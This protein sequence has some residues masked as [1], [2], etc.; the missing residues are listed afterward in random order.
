MDPNEFESEQDITL[1]P[2]EGHRLEHDN[3]SA[4]ANRVISTGSR[5]IWAL[6]DGFILMEEIKPI[7]WLGTPSESDLG[8]KA[9]EQRHG[10]ARL[11]LGCFYVSGERNVLIDLGYGPRDEMNRGFM[12]GG[13][14]LSHLEGM[15]VTPD[16]IDII[17]LT[18]L[19][20]DHVGWLGS[21]EG[22]PTF[23][24]AQVFI[25]VADWQYFVEG[26]NANLPLEPHVREALRRLNRRGQI[27]FMEGAREIAPGVQRVPAPG[28]TPG[29]S[30]YVVEDSA[31]R[32]VLCGDA[33]YC[34]DH[35][36]HPEWQAE[37]DIDPSL[38]RQTRRMLIDDLRE[39]GGI[40]VGS[41]FPGLLAI[42]SK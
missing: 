12:I 25:G 3:L 40:A 33:M 22:E 16:D 5:D 39:H 11:P 21:E 14:L 29:H 1:P 42:P 17:G 30:V 8:Q 35:V 19:H 4:G 32:V 24:N 38:A 26:D 23:G 36:E 7:F 34:P 27:T 9:L 31:T 10:E 2:W 13:N 15:E 37:S 41:H 20:L 6:S 18:H 28:H